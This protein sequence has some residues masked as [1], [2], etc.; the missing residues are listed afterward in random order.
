MYFT[1]TQESYLK[2]CAIQS[3]Y[4]SEMSELMSKI[5]KK[6]FSKIIEEVKQVNNVFKKYLEKKNITRVRI[7][8]VIEF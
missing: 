5:S 7:D 8:D 2:K 4:L 1:R 3:N 6:K